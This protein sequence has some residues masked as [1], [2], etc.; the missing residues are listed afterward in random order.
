M[1]YR[2]RRI[3]MNRKIVFFDIDGTI[4][5]YGKGVPNDTKDAIRNLREN[6]H[7]AIICTGRTRNMV[8][9]EISEIGFDGII[10]GAGTYVECQDVFYDKR[11]SREYAQQVY[12]DM[13]TYGVLPIG[14]GVEAIYFDVKHIPEQYRDIYELYH[15]KIPQYVKDIREEESIDVSKF[16]GV[17]LDKEKSRYFLEKYKDDFQI[18]YHNTNYIEMIP[19]NYSKAKGIEYLIDKLNISIED[20]YAFGDGM[21]DYEML[22]YV[23]YGVAMGNAAEEFKKKIDIVTEEYNKG[24]ISNALKRFGLID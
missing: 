3:K 10:A 21:N 13:L 12:E 15:T 24:G 11:L 20:T 7:L 4:Y 1:I 16:S 6:G 8:F 9:P 5:M 19:A 18:I 2:K 22:K 23:R 14:E 17:L